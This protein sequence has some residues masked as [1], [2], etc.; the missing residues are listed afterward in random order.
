MSKKYQLVT[1]SCQFLDIHFVL[2]WISCAIDLPS[3]KQ[4]GYSDQLAGRIMHCSQRV[5]PGLFMYSAQH[6]PGVHP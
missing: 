1:N 3:N 6:S 4:P 5:F 2:W